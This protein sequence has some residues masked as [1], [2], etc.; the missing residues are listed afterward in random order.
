MILLESLVKRLEASEY[1]DWDSF[2]AESSQGTLFHTSY[3]LRVSGQ[4]FRIYGYFKGSELLAGLPLVSNVSNFGVKRAYHPYLTPYLGIVFKENKAKYVKRISDEKDICRDIAKSIKDDFGL[5]HIEFTPFVLDLQPFIWEG[6]TSGVKYTYMLELGDLENVWNEMDARRRNGIV[7]A[8]K[9][10]IYVE[11]GDDFK[12][13]YA[14][15]EKTFGR[16]NKNIHFRSAAFG[17]NEVLGQRNQCK[18]FLTKSK[19]GNTIGAVYIV[20][21]EKRS[22]C[23][24]SGYDSEANHRGAYGLAMWEA[25]KFTKNKLGL[26]QFDFEGSM[27]QPVEQAFRKFGGKLTPYYYVHWMKP[28]VKVLSYSIAFLKAGLRSLKVVS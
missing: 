18:S 13:V 19:S 9:D 23:I 4:E 14:T 10:G 16:Q 12:Q 1:D 6:F 17:Y 2:V 15:V 3:W 11:I 24:L 8:E 25:I 21:D 7:R 22:Y 26:N 28:Y 5:I 20:W 27:L